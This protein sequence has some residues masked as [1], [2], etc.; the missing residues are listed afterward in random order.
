MTKNL[1]LSIKIH[2]SAKEHIYSMLGFK[3]LENN[4]VT[5]ADVLIE[6][7]S[8]FIK[9]FNEN[10]RL[11][12]LFMEHLIDIV[13]FLGKQELAFRGHNESSNSLNKGNF[14][15]LFEMHMSRCSLEIHNHYKSIQNVFSGLS[16]NTK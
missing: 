8:L 3:K 13:L 7:G 10:V 2:E 14:K 11:N 4:S 16:N 9:K 1:S 5:I 6:H 12:R 15:E